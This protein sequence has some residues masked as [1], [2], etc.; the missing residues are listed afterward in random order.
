MTAGIAVALARGQTFEQA[1]RVGAAAGALNVTRRGL[2]TGHEEAVT[3]LVER[4]V[5]R[6]TP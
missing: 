5:L 6:E 2:A 1:L 3:E 4:V